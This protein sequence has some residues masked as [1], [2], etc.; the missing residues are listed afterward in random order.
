[1]DLDLSTL[2]YGKHG[3]RSSVPASLGLMEPVHRRDELQQAIIASDAAMT[4]RGEVMRRIAGRRSFGGQG[5][6]HRLI[7]G[8]AFAA[9]PALRGTEPDEGNTVT[10]IEEYEAITGIYVDIQEE[11]RIASPGWMDSWEA[12]HNYDKGSIIKP[13]YYNSGSGFFLV[14]VQGGLSDSAEPLW[15]NKPESIFHDNDAI[16]KWGD[17]HTFFEV[18]AVQE[19]TA[20]MTRKAMRLKVIR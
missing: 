16:W 14:C 12:D 15:N 18:A 20:N 9:T 5:G 2:L 6:G 3:N 13:T 17:V 7:G 19:P 1:M 4:M 10:N 11:D 8:I